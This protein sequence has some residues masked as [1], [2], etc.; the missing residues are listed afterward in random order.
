[1]V[2]YILYCLID[3]RLNPPPVAQLKA[4]AKLRRRVGAQAER[5]S[6]E[7]WPIASGDHL[8]MLAKGLGGNAAMFAAPALPKVTHSLSTS[9]QSSSGPSSKPDVDKEPVGVYTLGRGL[10]A[11]YGSTIQDAL[12]DWADLGEK[13]KKCVG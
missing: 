3:R 5:L 7:V 1:M 13:M 11:Q 2:G 6:S 12:G 9:S 10:Y 4:E 8:G